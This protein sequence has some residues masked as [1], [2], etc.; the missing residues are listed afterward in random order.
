[1]SRLGL[2]IDSP[3][4]TDE[5]LARATASILQTRA[6]LLRAALPNPVGAC[7]FA[8]DLT[9][10]E[11]QRV[12]AVHQQLCRLVSP[13]RGAGRTRSPLRTR[14]PGLSDRAAARP[15]TPLGILAATLAELTVALGDAPADVRARLARDAL[16]LARG[17]D[18]YL[19]QCT[20]PESPALQAISEATHARTW[21]ATTAP[22]EQEM[23]SGHVEGQTLKMLV[24]LTRARRVLD[25]GMFT[26]YSALAMAE[27]LPESAARWWP[28]RS[29]RTSPRWPAS[30]LRREPARQRGSASW[31]GRHGRRCSPPRRRR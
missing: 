9:V 4:L 16:E 13:R 18:P 26:G 10:P 25:V 1:M 23:L 21:A 3:A 27:A 30:L 22:L 28:A 20:T 14:D 31:S 15:V 2:T 12:L 29:T 17:L 8:N 24:A 5:L 7:V 19:E 6:G 11:L